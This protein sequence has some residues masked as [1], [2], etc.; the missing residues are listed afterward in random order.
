MRE[1]SAPQRIPEEQALSR[2]LEDMIRK[3]FAS[4]P[5]KRPRATDLKMS[6][7]LTGTDNTDDETSMPLPKSRS[8]AAIAPM[9]MS[10]GRHGSMVEHRPL[11]FSRYHEDF[12]QEARLGK[13]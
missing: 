12:I 1:F 7:F 11:H 6:T 2:S 9:S 8:S 10:R 5:K 3:L 4:D 13:G